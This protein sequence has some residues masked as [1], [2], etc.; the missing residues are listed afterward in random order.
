MIRDT[1][2]DLVYPSYLIAWRKLACGSIKS[3][4]P[5]YVVKKVS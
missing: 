2:F 1:I 4:T 5:T 3:S